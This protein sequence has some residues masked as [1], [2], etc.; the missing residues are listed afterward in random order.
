VRRRW[1]RFERGLHR[2]RKPVAVVFM[3]G[4]LALDALAWGGVVARHEPKLVLH[5]STWALIYSAYT[6]LLVAE[7]GD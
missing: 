2:T 4:A 5:L 6:M 3:A 1:G 7:D